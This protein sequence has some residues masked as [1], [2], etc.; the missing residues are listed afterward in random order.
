MATN[1]IQTYSGFR[2]NFDPNNLEFNDV[3]IRDIRHSLALQCRWT[4]HTLFHYSIAQHSCYAFDIAWLKYEDMS[5]AFEALMHDASEAYLTDMSRPIKRIVP[6]YNTLQVPI[7]A[8]ISRCFG[9]P[10]VMTEKVAE[11]DNRLL[12][13]EYFQ[14]IDCRYEIRHEGLMEYAKT[15]PAYPFLK[16]E[17]WTPRRAE[18]E[19]TNRYDVAIKYKPNRNYQYTWKPGI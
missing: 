8:Y 15:Y 2:F 7:E 18:D 1:D 16:I 14:L 11:I 9:L 19:F 6:Q 17:E 3:D 10:E 5:L 12:I 13:T 4:G